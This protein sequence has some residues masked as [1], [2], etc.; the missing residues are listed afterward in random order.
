MKFALITPIFDGCINSLELLYNNIATQTHEDWLWILVGN[1]FSTKMLNYTR[2][3][4]KL[5]G[6][7]RISYHIANLKDEKNRFSL[8]ANIGQRRDLC[9]RYINADYFIMLNA[10]SKINKEMLT[11]I[12]NQL[13]KTKDDLCIYKTIS[14][15]GIT[16]PK[17]PFEYKGIDSLNYCISAKIA[18]KVGYPKNAN[19]RQLNDWRFFLRVY[20]K[21]KGQY[22]FIDKILGE[23]N[24][25]N[26]Y[27]TVCTIYWGDTKNNQFL[28]DYLSYCLKENYLEGIIGV[29]K[30]ALITRAGIPS[31]TF[32]EDRTYQ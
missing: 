12:N 23:Y 13:E 7:N 8:I 27:K 1:Q 26:R 3:K 10:D 2:S 9:I 15:H 19:F 11:T 25:N 21:C 6:K 14:D 22:S 31:T 17:R 24:A 29:L 30:E 20:R 5:D 4:Q 16:F 28:K 18:K 32:C